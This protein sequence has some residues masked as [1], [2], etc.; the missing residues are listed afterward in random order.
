M[1]KVRVE[2]I[3]T[4]VKDRNYIVGRNKVRAKHVDFLIMEQTAGEI[5]GVI[6]LNDSSHFK[7]DRQERDRFLENVFASCGID[8]LWVPVAGNYENNHKIV[9]FIEKIT[10]T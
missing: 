7:V 10:Q 9:E 3:V 4:A 2:D 1:S 8:L 6:E 5:R